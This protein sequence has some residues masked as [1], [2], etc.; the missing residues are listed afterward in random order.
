LDDVRRSVWTLA[1]PL[2]DGL[3][4]T[5]ALEQLTERFAAHAGLAATYSHTG[6]SPKLGHATATQVLRIAQEALQNAAKHAQ[7]TEVQVRSVVGDAEVCVWVEDNGIGFNPDELS[8]D[9]P[10]ASHGFGL[11]SL[12]ERA[13]LAGGMLRIESTPGKGTRVMVTVPNV[14]REM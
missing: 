1:S 12:H 9:L 14:T 5:E 10:A 8:A 7:A 3:I 2:V 11:L 13:R 6:G 4:L